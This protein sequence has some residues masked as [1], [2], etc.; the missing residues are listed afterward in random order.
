LKG[1]VFVDKA[2][3]KER[4]VKRLRSFKPNIDQLFFEIYFGKFGN[5]FLSR[6]VLTT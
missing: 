4:A 5:V 3:L 2:K 6:I 1:L